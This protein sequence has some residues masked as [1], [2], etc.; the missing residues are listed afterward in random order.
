VPR[1]SVSTRRTHIGH[2]PLAQPEEP[3]PR[4]RRRLSPCALN[5]ARRTRLVCACALW[6]VYGAGSDPSIN[7]LIITRAPPRMLTFFNNDQSTNSD[8][9]SVHFKEV[10][11]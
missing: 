9:Q 7:H 4:A 11:N 2:W 1:V 3:P 6:Q 5:L 10:P 8:Y